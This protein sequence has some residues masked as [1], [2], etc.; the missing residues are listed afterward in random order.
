[1]KNEQW[2]KKIES[3]IADMDVDYPNV[4][5]LCYEAKEYRFASVQVFPSMVE[6]CADVIGE[7]PVKICALISYPHGGFS[8]EQKV[9]EVRDAMSKGA[10]EAE[11]VINT[12][13]AKS[14]NWEYIEKEMT[15]VKKAVGN[16]IA[17]KFNIEIEN[18]TDVQAQGVCAAA[19]R[20]GIDWI[21]TS[22][23]EYCTLDENKN[24][25]PI[26][27]DVHDIELIKR[28]VGDKIRIQAEGN[29]TDFKTALLLKNAGANRIA[30]GCAVKIIKEGRAQEYV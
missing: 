1:M 13:E 18:L 17:V 16:H 9:F 23:G 29:I 21:A 15:A 12:R 8:I 14:C 22:T 24:D 11:V 7:Y 28:V 25:V 19:L 3:R 27:T 2:T 10:T 6:M 30:T 4:T 20:A 26:V 5:N